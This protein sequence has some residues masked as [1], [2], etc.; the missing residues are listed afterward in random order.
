M[1]KKHFIMLAIEFG[2]LWRDVDRFPDRDTVAAVTEA[3]NRVMS[4]CARSNPRFDR[5]HFAG[6]VQ[7]IRRGERDL[8]GKKV[9]RVAVA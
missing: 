3:Q 2:E 9:R 6:F 8:D 1:T 7:E 5:D 4:V